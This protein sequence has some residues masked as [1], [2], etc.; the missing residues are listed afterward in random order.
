LRGG[1]A[2]KQATLA[3]QTHIQKKLLK[4]VDPLDRLP[5]GIAVPPLPREEPEEVLV[6]DP[7]GQLTPSQFVDQ[8]LLA[9]QRTGNPGL[10]LQAT[11]K[12]Q[13]IRQ[14]TPG[15]PGNDSCLQHPDATA[16]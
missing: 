13:D 15:A 14:L 9:L 3:S 16:E 2:R 10:Y 7:R 12:S 5:V 6:G 11:N 4:Q 1:V 8:K